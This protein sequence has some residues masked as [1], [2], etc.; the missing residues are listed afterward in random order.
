MSDA[1][2][3]DPREY[4]EHD[5]G[6]ERLRVYERDRDDHD[7][8]QLALVPR[9]STSMPWLAASRDSSAQS[10]YTRRGAPLRGRTHD[11]GD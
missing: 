7:T 2:W 8:H 11:D 4:G 3:G 9:S 1:R 10:G 5:R 6:D